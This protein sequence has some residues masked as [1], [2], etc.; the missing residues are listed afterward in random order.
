MDQSTAAR[1]STSDSV[2]Y[3]SD[4]SA[5]ADLQR[6]MDSGRIER[7]CVTVIG[8]NAIRERLGD[9]WRTRC[10]WVWETV[11][12][13][14]GRRL[15]DHGFWV[16]LDDVDIAI[17]A[18]SSPEISRA[19]SLSLLREL[20][21]FFLGSHRIEDMRIAT[22][23]WVRDGEIAC[24]PLDPGVIAELGEGCTFSDPVTPVD[25]PPP[26]DGWS[27]LSFLVGRG[28]RLQVGLTFEP[29]IRLQNRLPVVTR[30]SLQAR[31]R[32]SGRVQAGAWMERL[33]PRDQIAI[34][35]AVAEAAA[36]TY[37]QGQVGVIIPCSIYALSSARSR[38]MLVECLEGL[39]S[40]PTKPVVVELTDIDQGTPEGRL[41][42]A[43]AL[44][45][46]HCRAVIAR[47]SDPA[48]SEGLMAAR[49]A[50]A[51]VECAGLG[52]RSLAKR[53]EAV[54]R[55]G[56]AAG[57]LLF[58]FGLS[59]VAACDAAQAAGATHAGLTVQ[60]GRAGKG[61]PH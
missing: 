36:A 6:L 30:L 31:D 29:V 35:A 61:L 46:P 14:L 32:D 15:R 49:L 56:H 3:L 11:A 4:T 21:D 18:G 51:A 20:L 1:E 9:K 34:A 47:V 26:G 48:M 24:D 10:D 45:A 52:V 2:D 23:L 43:G 57:L 53:L 42:D 19:V 28:S 54:S 33:S 41:L 50:G 59:S 17:S 16:R 25:A 60:A 12:A 40:S 38:A 39:E 8:L 27:A 55:P 22:V 13:H 5:R 7:G 44:L 37:A 58:A